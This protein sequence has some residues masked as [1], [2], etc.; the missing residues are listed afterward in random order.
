ML[1]PL[2]T[3]IRSVCV[4]LVAA[5]LVG[6]TDTTESRQK[7]EVSIA[8]SSAE[9][10]P[11]ESI[12]VTVTAVN[13]GTRPVVIAANPCP[14]PFVVTTA[15]DEV[16]GPGP[17]VCALIAISQEIAPGDDFVFRAAWDGDAAGGQP[18]GSPVFLNPG[19]YRVRGQVLADYAMVESAP[20]P[21]RIA[22]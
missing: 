15:S 9:V 16:V 5:A 22:P 3:S 8:L 10:K 1:M 14:D 21:V 11:G 6:C 18:G 12:E 7:L 2:F 17:Q 19:E 13:R 4:V 20:V